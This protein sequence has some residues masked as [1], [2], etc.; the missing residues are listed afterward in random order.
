MST[1]NNSYE[2][3]K[4]SLKQGEAAGDEVW[5]EESAPS[6]WVGLS[7]IVE[8]KGAFTC[9]LLG[10]GLMIGGFVVLAPNFKHLTLGKRTVG[11]VVG[12]KDYINRR[13]NNIVAPI[14]RYSAPGGVYDF[15]GGLSVSRS[16]YPPGKE[17]S[18]LYLPERPSNAVIADFVQIFMVP[19]VVSGLG[20]I[21]LIG[22]A[23]FMY[24]VVRMELPPEAAAAFSIVQR[25]PPPAT[26]APQTAG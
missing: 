4:E 17:V 12:H 18:V 3:W 16:L 26:S 5:S 10:V 2:S 8:M 25:K 21:C 7:S 6:T 1:A 24:L 11:T 19:A 22:T 20:L 23:G 9:L 14:V 13:S 15:V